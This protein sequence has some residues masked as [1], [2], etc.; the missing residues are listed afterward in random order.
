MKKLVLFFIFLPFMLFSQ[1]STPL[2]KDGGIWRV[3]KAGIV[4]PPDPW[5][6]IKEQ[7]LMEGDT[8]FNNETY[9]KIYRC[10]YS[11]SIY[12]KV[13]LGGI[14]E[15]S[16][17][18]VYF[19]LGSNMS[20]FTADLLQPM[21]TYLLYDFSLNIGDVLNVVNSQNSIQTLQT[22]DSVL[23]GNTYRKRWIFNGV[24]GLNREW[25]EGIGDVQGLF[26][27]LQY[28]FED[29]QLL[30]CYEDDALFWNNPQLS[31]AD[32]FT[33]G[34]DD[35]ESQINTIVN[36]YPNP[37]LNKLSIEIP[38]NV[39]EDFEIELFDI[40]GRSVK[41]KTYSNQ[42]KIDVNIGDLNKGIYILRIRAKGINQSIKVI[43]K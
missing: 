43:K 40:T 11:P 9:K 41:S 37:V 8:I 2:I 19:Y 31:G 13:F 25:I 14:R 1:Q 5:W 21:T 39:N 28:T 36:V 29:Q 35:S 34:I 27:P 20:L 3:V 10:D 18:K 16:L 15:D 30:S 6:I 12:N 33:V 38:N 22:I 17:N 7:Y 42:K 26:F 4:T 24:N 32:C 23:V